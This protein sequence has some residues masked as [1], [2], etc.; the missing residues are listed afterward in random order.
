MFQILSMSLGG[1]TL[2]VHLFR[3]SDI[4]AELKQLR[5][6]YS[7]NISRETVT[8]VVTVSQPVHVS[9]D[10]TVTRLREPRKAG[11]RLCVVCKG[12]I[13]GNRKTCS[14]KCRQRLSRAS[15][16]KKKAKALG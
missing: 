2:A 1:F 12:P 8:P 7:R 9:R 4:E 3:H 13:S 15:R 16:A 14:D 5:A 11:Q 10:K 6:E